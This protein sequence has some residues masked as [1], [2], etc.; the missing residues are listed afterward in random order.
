[1]AMNSFPGLLHTAGHT[2]RADHA[3]C[4]N[5]N[6]KKGDI[7]DTA[8]DWSEVAVRALSH[9]DSSMGSSAPKPEMSIIQGTLTWSTPCVRNWQTP[10]KEV[11]WVYLGKIQCTSKFHSFVGS[12]WSGVDHNDSSLLENPY[13]PYNSTDNCVHR[14]RFNLNGIIKWIT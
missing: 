5:L 2:T 7:V 8:S 4:C 10:P 14:F 12:V 3:Q 1:M 13:I 9:I 11:R 6:H